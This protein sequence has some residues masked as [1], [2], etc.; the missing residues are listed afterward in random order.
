M[1]TMVSISIG[2]III[3]KNAGIA[4]ISGGVNGASIVSS[5]NTKVTTNKMFADI[6]ENAD[7]DFCF[8]FRLFILL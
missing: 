5:N 1:T 2:N 7:L 4:I 8:V 6:I 3:P